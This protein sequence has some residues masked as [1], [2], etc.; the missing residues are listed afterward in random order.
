MLKPVIDPIATLGSTLLLVD[1]APKFEQV[2]KDDGK[3]ERTDRIISY[4]YSVICVNRK[5]EK[6]LIK[7]D[8]QRPL[9]DTEKED[10][11]ENTIVAFEN[12]TITP[13]VQNGWIQL[14]SKADKCFVC[15]EE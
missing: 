5:Y 13:Y 1:I 15:E 6:L 8:E 4:V 2:K 9:F 7:I 12:L 10:I 11:P 3:F 14:S